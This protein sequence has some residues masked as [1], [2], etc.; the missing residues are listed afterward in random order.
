MNTQ[1]KWGVLGLAR[2][3]RNEFIPALQ[4]TAGVEL[5]AV[6]SRDQEKLAEFKNQTQCAQYYSSY[7]ALL[8]D[9]EVQ[10]VYIPLP[11]ALHKEW[12]IQAA[13]RGKHVLCEKP[14]ALNAAECEAIIA[15]ARQNQVVV[16]EGFMYRYSERTK[17]LQDILATG[18]LGDL[19]YIHSSYRFL[20]NRPNTIKVQPELGGGSLYDVGCYPVNFTGMITGMEPESVVAE[21]V[22]ENGVDMIFSAVLKYPGWILATIN[23]GFNAFP[24][25][26]SELI[27]TRGRIEIPD[28]FLGNAGTL[29]LVTEAGT[30]EIAVAESDRFGREIADFSQAVLEGK[31]P[32]L[33]L[34]ETLRNMKVIESLLQVARDKG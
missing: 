33:S 25:I 14:I 11:N 15:A 20:L 16:M 10:A 6:A 17:K 4:R 24:R 18:V 31:Y 23:S 5:Y 26:F 21:A 19:K 28:T 2:I 9:P 3:A 29:T 8:D 34:E 32:R 27:G 22:Y 30:E 12:V 1:V 7:E 13:R